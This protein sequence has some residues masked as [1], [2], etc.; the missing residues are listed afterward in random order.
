M[1]DG[2]EAGGASGS[3]PAAPRVYLD[4][5]GCRLNQSELEF[6]GRQFRVA[7]W[8]LSGEPAECDW[9]VINTCAVTAAAAADSR[10]KARRAWR[11]N[12]NARIVLTGCLATIDPQTL[13]ALPGAPEIVPNPKK[14]DLVRTVTGR[15]IPSYDLEPIARTPLPG[16]RARTRAFIKAQDGCDNHCTFCITT[17]AR[18]PARSLPLGEV[19]EAV[20]AAVAGGAKEAV[21][22]GVQLS[23]Y[24]RDLNPPLTLTDLV[25][26]ILEHTDIARLRLSSLEPWSIPPDLFSLWPHPRLCRQ[27]HL[28][29]QSGCRQTLRRMA[30]PITPEAF[31][32]QVQRARDAIPQVAIT[33]DILVGFP[34]ETEEEFSA[35]LEFIER[36]QPAGAHL[37]VY[38][39]RPGTAAIRLPNPVPA[40]VAHQRRERVRAVI[41][42]SAQA[43]RQQFVGAELT[44][45][46][47]SLRAKTPRGWELVGLTDNYLRLRAVAQQDLRNRLTKVRVLGFRGEMG[48]AEIT[49]PVAE[50]RRHA[51]GDP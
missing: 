27:L 5:V 7:G 11:A 46:W 44:A 34:G 15:A 24:G 9:V 29:L 18:G 37:F 8:E 4:S 48:T 35:S 21:L 10:A 33:T 41:D 13:R 51:G 45:L 23:A 26:A 22:T 3:H 1:S 14:G 30:R 16:L 28:P 43:Y 19:L 31:M 38:S 6:L 20:N 49:H 25:R 47:E 2:Q 50:G 42:R 17:I 39:P 40:Q 12:P 32:R 36:L